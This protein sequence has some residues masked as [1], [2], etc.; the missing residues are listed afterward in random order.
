MLE[1]THTNLQKHVTQVNAVLQAI[2]ETS[3]PAPLVNLSDGVIALAKSCPPDLCR[4]VITDF[5]I[6]EIAVRLWQNW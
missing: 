1:A 4:E 3:N 5:G 2:C 6:R